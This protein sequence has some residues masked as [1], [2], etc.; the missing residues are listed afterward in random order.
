MMKI[1]FKYQ[2]SI[3]FKLTN[4]NRKH[5]YKYDIDVTCNIYARACI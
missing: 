4:N 1:L 2:N 5:W 3:T